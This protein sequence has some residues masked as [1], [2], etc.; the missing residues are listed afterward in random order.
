MAD[1][2]GTVKW[3]L[4]LSSFIPL[5]AILAY[6]HRTVYLTLPLE[7]Y[8]DGVLTDQTWPVLTVI[9]IVLSSISFVFLLLVLSVRKSR[10]GKFKDIKS[11]QSRND[12]VTSYILVY[13]FP[14]VVLDLSKTANWVAFVGFFL[15]IGVIQTRSNQLHV[16]PIL[17]LMGYDIYEVDD[18]SE[19]FILLTKTHPRKRESSLKTVELS[20][21]VL[22]AV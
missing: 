7:Q 5:Y 18:G 10:E 8:T 22:I 16:N 11:Y 9:W 15:V 6:K 3:M 1:L 2:R 21:D 20:N 14:F 17:A 19:E 12:L 4:F 13:I